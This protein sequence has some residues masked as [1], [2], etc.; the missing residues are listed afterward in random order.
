MI[1]KRFFMPILALVMVL[2]CSETKIDVSQLYNTYFGQLTEITGETSTVTEIKLELK[3]DTFIITNSKTNEVKSYAY[4]AS[5]ESDV[6]VLTYTSEDKKEVITVKS[7][8]VNGLVILSGNVANNEITCKTKALVMQEKVN[9]YATFTLTADINHLTASEKQIL[10]LLF[11]IAQIMDELF[12]EQ[13]CPNK[14]ELLGKIT[15]PNVK[16]F[17]EINYGPWDHLDDNKSFIEGV[18]DKDPKGSFYPA[19][20]TAEEFE[21]F[22][23]KTKDS[24]YTII[25]RGEDGKLKSIPYHEF[26]GEKLK[27]AIELLRKAAGMAENP[28]LKKYLELRATA[29]ETSNYFES[30]MAWM[31]MKNTNIDFVVGPIESYNDGLNGSKTSFESFVLIKDPEWSKKLEKFAQLLPTMQKN[32]P[33]DDKYKQEVPGKDSDLGVYY[34][35]YYG[36]DCNGGSKTIAINLPN[37]K[38]VNAKK[39]SRKLQLK[40]S[41]QA[42]FEKILVPISE[43]LITEEQRKNITFD[44]FFENTMFHEIAHGLAVSTTINGK[45][46]VSAA[47]KDQHTSLEEGKADIV[48]LYLI[49][50]L[51]EMGEITDKDLLNN[52]VTF[53]AG[54]FRSS[55]FGAGSAHGKANMVRFNYFN[56]KG[57]F[58]RDEK[59][60]TYKVN[61]E[62]MKTA[63]TD[64]SKMIIEIQGNGDYDTAKKM[65]EERGAM[66]D[67]LKNDL[68]RITNAN[69]P[70]DIVF[71]QGKHVIGL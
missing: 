35:L 27:K 51:H 66:S 53:M 30:D 56:E 4:V 40:N 36:G 14:D 62:I 21:K 61:F 64:L 38:E 57:A 25:R 63:V 41:M 7:N 33:V 48:G 20:M 24:W 46:L 8:A 34:A 54:I 67:M 65:I 22:D 49:T 60:G 1:K 12:W 19:D 6:F 37:D 23:D 45:G 58:T 29:L 31:D 59:T 52:Y 11:E 68:Q 47:L 5:K 18:S 10:P 28:E 13:N 32:L 43:I 44:A 26:Y 17:F 9:E 39:G 69:I 3:A 15:D 2:G 16:R 70:K 71:E 50:K 55:R 42:K